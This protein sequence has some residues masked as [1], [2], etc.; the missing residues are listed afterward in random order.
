MVRRD[1]RLTQCNLL[2]MESLSSAEIRSLPN[3]IGRGTI[4]D[5]W[6]LSDGTLYLD[7]AATRPMLPEVADAMAQLM[8]DNPLNAS[9]SHRFGQKA[10]SI[11]EDTRAFISE[12]M[13]APEGSQLVFNSGA[14]EGITAALTSAFLGQ[15]G[16]NHII[17]VKTEHKAVLNT[18]SFLEDAG[19][20]VTYLDVDC[21][22]QIS[23]DELREAIRPTTCAVCLMWVNNETGAVSPIRE[24]GDT[25]SSFDVPV[26]VDATQALVKFPIDLVEFNGVDVLVGSAHKIGGPIGLGLVWA[27]DPLFLKSMIHGGGQEF[28]KRS[29]TLNIAGVRGFQIAWEQFDCTAEHCSSARR[30]LERELFGEVEF[31]RYLSGSFSPFICVARVLNGRDLFMMRPDICVSAGSACSNGLVH[32]S[33]VYTEMFDNYEDLIRVSF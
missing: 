31:V 11:L 6:R 17:T 23:L 24:I 33:H 3:E 15:P 12:A 28:G 22:G 4:L 26:I 18:C 13:N 7:N 9:S 25:C 1:E 32:E 27:R 10:L 30:R 2:C 19:A 21:F 5:R 20:K 8:V 29:G 14:T 16:K